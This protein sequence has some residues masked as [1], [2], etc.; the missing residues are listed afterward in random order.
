[1]CKP[2]E[3]SCW[4]TDFCWTKEDGSITCEAHVGNNG[5]LWTKLFAGGGS[6]IS[7]EGTMTTQCQW[8]YPGIDQ[9]GSSAYQGALAA[10]TTGFYDVAMNLLDGQHIASHP[11]LYLEN[12]FSIWFDVN[13]QDDIN[14]LYGNIAAVYAQVNSCE[15]QFAGTPDT[16]S[17]G[18]IGW[19]GQ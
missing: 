15:D 3:D 2:G 16:V 14:L 13:S 8:E 5:E 19:D 9:L 1:V 12:E 7:K 17:C 10:D 18:A 6:S 11:G 4:G